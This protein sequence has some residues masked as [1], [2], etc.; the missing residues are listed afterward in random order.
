MSCRNETLDVGS[1]IAEVPEVKVEQNYLCDTRRSQVFVDR[2]RRLRKA[3]VLYSRDPRGHALKQHHV[4]VNCR[5]IDYGDHVNSTTVPSFGVL[6]TDAVPWI[7]S[8]RCRI[9]RVMPRPDRALA[10][11]NPRPRSTIVTLIPPE[12]SPTAV[13]Q[14]S[15][16]PACF[17]TLFSASRVAL[18]TAMTTCRGSA[19]GSS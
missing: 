8:I 19:P 12:S 1:W 6:S 4:V 17:A 7:S 14:A 11:S 10:R 13:S 15:L 2:G 18:I 9:E 16:A 5:Y 3:N